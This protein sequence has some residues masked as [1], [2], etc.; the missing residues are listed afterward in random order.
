MEFKYDLTLDEV[1]KCRD[2]L[3]Y[4]PP[5]QS[6]AVLCKKLTEVLKNPAKNNSLAHP[7]L[8]SWLKKKLQ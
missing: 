4:C 7:R 2:A 3:A 8:M 1:R 5:Q 6:D